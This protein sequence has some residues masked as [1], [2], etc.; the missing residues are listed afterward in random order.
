[1]F[2]IF[3][4]KSQPIVEEENI[5]SND[6]I[7]ID[8]SKP[9]RVSDIIQEIHSTFFNESDRLLAEAKNLKPLDTNIQDQL[10]KAKKLIELG[11]V[12]ADV[13]DI[14]AKEEKRLEIIKAENLRNNNLK[15]AILYFNKKYPNYKFITEDSVKTICNK[16]NLI[17][18]SVSKYIGEVPDKNLKEIE[19]FNI[20]IVDTAWNHISHEFYSRQRSSLSGYKPNMIEGQTYSSYG[21]YIRCSQLGFQIVAPVSKFNTQ[22]MKLE[23]FQ[24]SKIE[25]PDP[26]VLKPVWHKSFGLAYLIVSAWGDEASDE[27]VK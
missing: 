24:L 5:I 4:K 3:K 7:S 26:I 6:N 14:A 25:I 9:H 20:D 27:L 11:F 23:N 19:D 16:Y 10:D 17:Y 18:G 13:T 21:Q 22:G 2:S 8:L 15:D 12:N 1:M